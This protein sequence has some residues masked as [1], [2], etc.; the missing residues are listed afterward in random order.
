MG[1][2]SVA[3][4]FSAISNGKFIYFCLFSIV[5]FFYLHSFRNVFRFQALALSLIAEHNSQQY[6]ISFSDIVILSDEAEFSESSDEDEM[7]DNDQQI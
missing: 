2:L 3:Y 4:R 6:F 7:S 1:S 5:L